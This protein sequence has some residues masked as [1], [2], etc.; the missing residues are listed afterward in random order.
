MKHI[1]SLIFLI[2][3]SGI[4]YSQNY[5][6]STLRI[7]EYKLHMTH[8]EAEKLANKK[9][10]IPSEQNEYNGTTIVNYYG[11]LVE[12]DIIN[13]G[14]EEENEPNKVYAISTKSPKFRTKSGMGVG[15]TR[16]EILE[17]FKNYS[18]YELYPEYDDNGKVIKGS[19]YFRLI[20]IDAETALV[21]SFVNNKVVSVQVILNMGCG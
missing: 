1:F 5:D 13:H 10:L 19:G 6:L 2:T 8:T 21:F 20:D 9:L 15:S 4:V 17:T 11:E 16:D 12:I 7:G 18:S 14:N 3:F